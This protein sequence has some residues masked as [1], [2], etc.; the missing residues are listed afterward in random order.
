MISSATKIHIFPYICN[1]SG[2]SITFAVNMKRQTILLL[3]LMA[4]LTTTTAQTT[5]EPKGVVRFF[6][7][8][9]FKDGSVKGTLLDW[10]VNA[11]LGVRF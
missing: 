8:F 10:Y 5:K 4:M 3:C 2:K 11:S 9:H 6:S 1:N 7:R